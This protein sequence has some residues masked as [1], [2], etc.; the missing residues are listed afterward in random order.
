MLTS[1]VWGLA[2]IGAFV[3]LRYLLKE[4]LAAIKSSGLKKLYFGAEF[5]ENEKPSKRLKD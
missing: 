3:V 4:I 1:I 2:C 5:H